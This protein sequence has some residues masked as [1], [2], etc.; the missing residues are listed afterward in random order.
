VLYLDGVYVERPD[1]S[2]HFRWVKTSTSGERTALAHTLARRVGWD[3][4]SHAKSD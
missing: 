1:G 4:G 3:L 2:V